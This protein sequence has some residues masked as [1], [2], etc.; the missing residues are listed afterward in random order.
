MGLSLIHIFP[1]VSR[2]C[3]PSRVIDVVYEEARK[4]IRKVADYTGIQTGPLSMQF[5]YK[6]GQGIE[7]CECAGRLFGYEHELVTYGSKMCIRD[8]Q[9]SSGQ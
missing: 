8:R 7:V 6:A 2:V 5:F 1:H 9:C 4:I 3:Y